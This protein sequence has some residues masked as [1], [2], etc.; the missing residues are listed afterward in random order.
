MEPW[1]ICPNLDPMI[2]K[3]LNPKCKPQRPTPATAAA[4]CCCCWCWRHPASKTTT[5]RSHASKPPHPRPS[6]REDLSKEQGDL[7]KLRSQLEDLITRVGIALV[8][9]ARA[10]THSSTGHAGMCL[11]LWASR[12]CRLSHACCQSL[13]GA[14]HGLLQGFAACQIMPCRCNRGC[15]SFQYE[16]NRI[17]CLVHLLKYICI[18]SLN[19][20]HTCL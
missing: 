6:G 3:I 13:L 2:R 8:V 9:E 10:S 15:S 11:R 1:L 16:Q 7:V 14:V 20:M 17:Q 12:A 4:A 5:D 18:V 19:S